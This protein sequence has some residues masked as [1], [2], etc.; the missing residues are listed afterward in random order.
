[1]K[2]TVPLFITA[3]SGFALIVAFFVPAFEETGDKVAI[4]FDLLASI[5]FV[6]GGGNLLK[7]HLKKISDQVPGWGYSAVTI[8]A[9]LVTLYV[10][11]VKWGVPPT[12]QQEFFGQTF[13]PLKQEDLP[14]SLT[15]SVPGEIPPH[16]TGK[17]LPVSV[18]AQTSQ[19]GG[20]IQFRGWMLPSQ[21]SDLIGYSPKLEWRC[22]VENLFQ[23]AQ[24]QQEVLKGRVA[25]YFDHQ[26]L[27]FEGYM[28]D[29]H[30][31]ALLELGDGTAWKNAVEQL[32]EKSRTETEIEAEKPASIV[33]PESLADVI[34]YDEQ[35]RRLTVKGPMSP[36]QVAALSNQIPVSRPYTAEQQR[37]LL[38]ELRERGPVNDEQA[39]TLEKHFLAG[40]SVDQLKGLLDEAGVPIEVQ[41]SFCELY[42]E[43]QAGVDPLSATRTE[44][45]E[46]KLND[47]QAALLQRFAEDADMTV[48]QLTQQLQEQG[49][50]TPSQASFLQSYL[51]RQ[52]T[53]AANMKDLALAMLRVGPL[54]PGQLDF[55]LADYRSQQKWK[56]AVSALMLKA[57]TPKYP[58]SGQY[59][60]QGSPFW[61]LYEYAFKPLTATMFAV[62]AFYVASAAFRAFR[63]KN[64][65]ALL[66][67]GTAFIILLGRTFAGVLLTSFIPE[68]SPGA[69][70]RIENLTV[71]IMTVFNTA[72]TRAIMIG[73]ALG[74]A[75]TSLRVLLG[76]DRSYLGSGED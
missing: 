20:E 9:F 5:A 33:I 75:S 31:A 51:G 26:A 28:T 68:D 35:S 36:R 16:P 73:I 74:I 42:Q 44:G 66:L 46:T 6:L 25:Y 61:W 49:D 53:V 22:T 41:K 34:Q 7:M 18:R 14:A 37:R 38:D 69:F 56:E 48:G 32:W 63:A 23:A 70:W 40:W 57:H 15:F 65:E 27:S 13:A 50:F 3:I 4:W 39:E 60:A 54:T 47:A 2:R 24:P 58:W 30:K 19:Q 52:P 67:L 64:V 1:M 72:G 17:P 76:I 11:M 62:L 10:G 71:Y 21:L 43:Q 45:E 8:L 59:R 29:E 12:P 55:L